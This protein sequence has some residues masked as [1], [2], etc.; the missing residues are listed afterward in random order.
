MAS[1]AACIGVSAPKEVSQPSAM[2]V[3]MVPKKK[4]AK[5]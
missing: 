5:K 2:A 3:A 4:A 1:I